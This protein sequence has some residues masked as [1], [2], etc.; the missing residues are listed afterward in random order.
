MNFSTMNSILLH[1][2]LLF[3]KEKAKKHNIKIE[4][5]VGE[6]PETIIADRKRLKQVLVNLLSNAIKFTP[7]NGKIWAGIKRIDKDVEFF[8]GDT[9]PG[10][11]IQ[12]MHK[13]FQPFQQ[14]G[15]ELNN[16]EGSGLGLAISKKLVEAHGGTIWVKTEYGK[17]SVFHFR[18]PIKRNDNITEKVKSEEL[19]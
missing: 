17:G 4:I 16:K 11:K 12:D 18:I 7:D 2:A 9:G 14:I 5:F 13:L 10:I 6:A 3:I 15:G 1:E 8:I 19:I